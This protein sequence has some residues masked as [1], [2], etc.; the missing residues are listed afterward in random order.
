MELQAKRWRVGVL[1]AVP[2]FRKKTT[3]VIVVCFRFSCGGT[4][5]KKRTCTKRNK[6]NH[7]EPPHSLTGR[8]PILEGPFDL[9]WENHAEQY[10]R[11]SHP[12]YTYNVTNAYVNI[13]AL[14]LCLYTHAWIHQQMGHVP[15]GTP[16]RIPT[17]KLSAFTRLGRSSLRSECG[18]RRL[19]WK[20]PG[21]FGR[22]GSIYR[23]LLGASMFV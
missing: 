1:R 7:R 17:S 21:P 14:H 3:T 10:A 2:N 13:W 18:S 6:P 9:F 11:L 5:Q 22:L 15:S 16:E 12:D 23:G 4:T 20:L 19:T 8:C